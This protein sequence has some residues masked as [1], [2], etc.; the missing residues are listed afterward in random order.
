M[1][2]EQHLPEE[3]LQIIIW[4]LKPST[5]FQCDILDANLVS[6]KTLLSC[7]Q[8][9][10]KLCRL[11]RPVF[12]HTINVGRNYLAMAHYFAQHSDVADQVRELCVPS[13]FCHQFVQI[14]YEDEYL[15]WPEYMYSR[16]AAHPSL[17]SDRANLGCGGYRMTVA[18][19]AL[20]ICSKVRNL[21]L[22]TTT[23]AEL[24]VPNDF[25]RECTALGQ[26]QRDVASVPLATLHNL[27]LEYP[28]KPDYHWDKS[29]PDDYWFSCL[30][31]LPQISS[32]NLHAIPSR[33]RFTPLPS[34]SLE[35]LTMTNMEVMP[36]N[37]LGELV[38]ACPMLECLDLTWN[39]SSNELVPFEWAEF[40]DILTTHGSRIRV[41][42]LNRSKVRAPVTTNKLVNLAAL[43]H[44]QSLTL[45]IEAV[46]SE[47]AGQYVVPV[48]ESE[49]DPSSVGNAAED[50]EA[51][52]D[53]D[54]FAA[55][56]PP[57]KG[58]NTP[59]VPLHQLLPSTLR[60]LKIVDDWDLWADAV[61][62]D[63]QLRSL[64]LDPRFSEL[65][66]IRVRRKMPFTKHVKGLGWQT[67]RRKR[68]W[69]I[70]SQ[71]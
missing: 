61:R 35:S 48:I 38:K 1:R 23:C 68:C 52:D 14:M 60:D 28:T 49:D 55:L 64:V 29:G 34:S 6:R 62:L 57:G 27:K 13:Q 71:H 47:S 36:A 16:L 18:T 54:E 5:G 63:I 43:S 22:E 10:K 58:L 37:R 11:A 51:T 8:A 20:I 59:T 15:Q 17:L 53:E 9:S 67:T 70:L 65:R 19:L 39:R 33:S 24:V 32:I 3:L 30:L 21:L 45:P 25:L 2:S 69:N 42:R 50:D 12:Y 26:T 44:L 7:M 66:T 4:Q 46:L 40:G 56:H 41:F 31:S